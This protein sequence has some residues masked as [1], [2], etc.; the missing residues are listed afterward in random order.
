MNRFYMIPNSKNLDEFKEELILPLEGYS[1]GF[2]VYFTSEEIERIAQERDVSVMIN[3]FLHKDRLETIKLELEGM[4]SVKFFF[5][6]DLGLLNIIERERVVLFQNHIV[7]NYS[8]VNY[9]E[10]INV[11][12]IVISNELTLE[13]IKVIRDKSFGNLF[14][15]L[16]N[17]NSLMYSKR[18]LISSYGIYKG[19]EF[20]NIKE[21]EERVS[22][23]Q[24]VVKEENGETIIFDRNLF[25]ANGVI[26]LLDGFNFIVN[27]NNLSKEEYNSIM[28][29]YKDKDLG[30]YVDIDDYYLHNKIIYKVGEE[31]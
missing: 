1:I 2:D 26:D 18:K 6:E 5:V 20:D 9:Y 3:T 28:N 17:R 16:I 14:Y 7:N 12:N 21:V 24:L 13:E 30:Y 4:S 29:H 25:S 23:R 27:F 22:K 31:K 11:K 19:E 15:F 8:A 10:G